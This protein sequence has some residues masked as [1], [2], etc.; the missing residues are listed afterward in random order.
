M[1]GRQLHP[2]RRLRHLAGAAQGKRFISYSWLSNSHNMMLFPEWKVQHH[3]GGFANLLVQR[4]VRARVEAL[5]SASH[6]P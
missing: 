1:R 3:V 4:K 5:L 6:E 2:R